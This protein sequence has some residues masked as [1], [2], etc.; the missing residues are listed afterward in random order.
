MNKILI[1]Y[2]SGTGNTQKMAELIAQGIQANGS[3]AVVKDVSAVTP[4][5]IND[6]SAV[7]LGCSSM[8]S[9][10]LS[11]E[12][13]S[14]VSDIEAHITNKKIALFGSYGWGDGEWMRDW[15]ERMKN[16][17]AKLISDEGLIVMGEPTADSVEDCIKLGKSIAK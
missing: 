8:G 16:C 14:F 5:E 12:M 6:Y 15:E 17:G 2:W 1:V 13:D 7:A 3:V 11:D 4:S 9:E 10:Q